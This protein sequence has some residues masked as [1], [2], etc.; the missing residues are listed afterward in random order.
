MKSLSKVSRMTS[1]M[2]KKDPKSVVRVGEFTRSNKG[3]A[4]RGLARAAMVGGALRA[5]GKALGK[6]LK[7]VAP[8]VKKLPKKPFN[9]Y[10]VKKMLKSVKY[11]E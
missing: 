4:V 2:K 3:G 5:A 7:P 11:G 6:K 9:Q 8:G 1:E 10:G